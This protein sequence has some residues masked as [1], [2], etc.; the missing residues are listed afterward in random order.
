MQRVSKQTVKVDDNWVEIIALGNTN[1]GRSEAT[2]MDD[3]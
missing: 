1:G 3:L 2:M